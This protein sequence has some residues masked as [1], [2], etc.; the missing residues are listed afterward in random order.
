MS[1]HAESRQVE[2]PIAVFDSGLGGLTVLNAL[3]RT[4]PSE[5]F[6]FFADRARVPYA[7]LSPA[8]ITRYAMESARFL[9]S[10]R[11]KAAVI[12]CNTVSA[13]ALRQVEAAL[14]VPVI[15]VLEP[16]AKA[17]ASRTRNKRVGVLATNA[18]V[19]RDTYA[20]V[21]ADLVPG[22]E[23]TSQGCPLL[24]PLVEE[25]WTEGD[26]PRLIVE[27]YL[28]RIQAARVDTVVLGCTHYEYFRDHIQHAMGDDVF[29]VDTP[30]VTAGE[31][32]ARIPARA[33]RHGRVK[34]FS[35]DVTDALYRV[36]ETLFPE[37]AQPEI[38]SI[39]IEELTLTKLPA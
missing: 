28:D 30:Q 26:I 21:L 13:V 35:S 20:H 36:V 15:N 31:L 29:L 7:S 6:V 24:V 2:G 33:G 23:V 10:H 11:P 12:A 16:T 8:L 39:S 25:G 4:L 17:A 37:D 18:T 32:L 9:A 19:K 5:D 3:H 38:E 1:L 14:D 27:H 22:V 34:I